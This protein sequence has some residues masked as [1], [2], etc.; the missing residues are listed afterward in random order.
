MG[1]GV[2]Q[3]TLHEFGVRLGVVSSLYSNGELEYA[4]VDLETR[5]LGVPVPGLL[6]LP[7][8]QHQCAL[9]TSQPRR[10]RHTWGK[11]YI[12]ITDIRPVKVWDYIHGKCM[13]GW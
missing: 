11:T 10:A 8:A 2:I 5:R 13:C 1:L 12:V 9:S 3:T 4:W 6:G 7:L